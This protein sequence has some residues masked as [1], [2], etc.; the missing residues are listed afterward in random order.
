MLA[1]AAA[2]A[3]LCERGAACTDGQEQAEREA[4]QVELGREAEVVTIDLAR[5]QKLTF[6]VLQT[7]SA[8]L[9]VM[10]SEMLVQMGRGNAHAW[11]AVAG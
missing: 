3:G 9:K 10:L 4:L 2:E 1:R 6:R 8:K 7:H 5:A 11:G